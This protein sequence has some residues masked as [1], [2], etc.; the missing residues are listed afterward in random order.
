[1]NNCQPLRNVFEVSEG[2][3]DQSFEQQVDLYVYIIKNNYNSFINNLF[4][5]ISMRDIVDSGIALVN[6]MYHLIEI[7]SSV[8]D[9]N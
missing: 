7:S 6:Y 9:I 1:M 4:T 2:N 3:I 5:V 8:T